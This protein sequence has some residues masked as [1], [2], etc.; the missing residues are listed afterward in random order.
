M[1]GLAEEQR[2]DDQRSSCNKAWLQSS[3]LAKPSD[4]RSHNNW[5]GGGT[6]S[7]QPAER[8]QQKAWLQLLMLAEIKRLC[9]HT[10]GL[11]EE[12]QA[13]EAAQQLAG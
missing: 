1:L 2:A 10:P 11:T 13:G 8:L 5:L 7:R 6:T 3:M 4:R 12:Q 9:S